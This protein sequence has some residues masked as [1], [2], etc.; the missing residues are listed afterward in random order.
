M[1]LCSAFL[2][3]HLRQGEEVCVLT[4]SRGRCL[5]SGCMGRWIPRVAHFPD[6]VQGA[7]DGLPCPRHPGCARALGYL[8]PG[9][10]TRKL[11][12]VSGETIRV[13][14]CFC[15]AEMDW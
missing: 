12:G 1:G 10:W 8:P 14:L 11:E 3:E 15:P 2:D 6:G 7:V 4:Y 5:V 9:L 13:G